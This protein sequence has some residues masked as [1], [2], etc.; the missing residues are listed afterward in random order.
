M[1]LSDGED[2]RI[3][4]A[5]WYTNNY[6][7]DPNNDLFKVYVSDNGGVGWTL[8]ETIGPVTSSGWEEYDFLVGDFVT[9]SEQLKV[10]FEA[11][12]LNDGSVVEAGIDDFQVFAYQCSVYCVDSD[13]DGYGDPG[14]PENECP[15]DNCPTVYNPG[16]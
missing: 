5:L 4:Y 2:A 8:V 1:D 13:S 16:Q 14:N 3:H 6:G 11:S 12:D 10:R 7:N 9:P 15:D